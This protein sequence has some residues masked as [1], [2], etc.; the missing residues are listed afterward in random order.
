M[1]SSG[2]SDRALSEWVLRSLDAGDQPDILRA[3]L[4]NQGYDPH[5][6]DL[7]IKSR[8]KQEPVQSRKPVP[9]IAVPK[10]PEIAKPSSEPGVEEPEPVVAAAAEPGIPENTPQVFD[11][12]AIE[13]NPGRKRIN[14]TVP[15]L[16]Q[17]DFEFP[18]I[19]LGID[20]QATRILAAGAVLLAIVA[21]IF[22]GLDWYADRMAKAALG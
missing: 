2:G 12:P 9:E 1:S 13:S 11:A 22:F 4:K 8:A 6:V 14:I 17:F 18:K 10:A 16:P 20:M 19:H 3:A 15:K 5:I 7:A 21:A